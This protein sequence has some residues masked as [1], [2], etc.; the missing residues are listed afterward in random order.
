MRTCIQS[1]VMRPGRLGLTVRSACAGMRNL[2]RD[3]RIQPGAVAHHLKKVMETVKYNSACCCLFLNSFCVNRGSAFCFVSYQR[4]LPNALSSILSCTGEAGVHQGKYH[5]SRSLA[6]F[7][8]YRQIARFSHS[9]FR[10]TAIHAGSA[11][12]YIS[13]Y[14]NRQEEARRKAAV[15]L[16]P[17]PAKTSV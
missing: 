3:T 5:A 11:N 7:A 13:Q 6:S 15:L 9:R 1:Q 8:S 14:Q 17:F 2:G 10:R 16:L 12:Y 4:L